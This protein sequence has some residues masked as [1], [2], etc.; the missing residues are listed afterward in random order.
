MSWAINK[1]IPFKSAEKKLT[2]QSGVHELFSE[3]VNKKVITSDVFRMKMRSVM[4]MSTDH[5]KNLL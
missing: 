1:K 3:A 2:K 4:R 5:S